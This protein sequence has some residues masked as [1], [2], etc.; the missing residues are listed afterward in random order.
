VASEERVGPHVQ[1]RTPRNSRTF[2]VFTDSR[3]ADAAPDPRPSATIA[4]RNPPPK[5]TL[6]STMRYP[7]CHYRA[8]H[9][10]GPGI[11]DGN[12]FVP[13]PVSAS[14]PRTPSA[15]RSGRARRAAP[16]GRASCALGWLNRNVV[17]SGNPPRSVW[18]QHWTARRHTGTRHRRIF[19]S[20]PPPFLRV[21]I[22]DFAPKP[23]QV[24]PR[25][26]QLGGWGFQFLDQF[27]HAWGID[28]RGNSR[29]IC[30]DLDR[31]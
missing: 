15:A 18:R 27:S 17:T 11:D 21:E 6:G 13:A 2:L 30:F 22:V 12:A 14:G 8:T 24:R 23:S 4:G 3:G 9:S 20:D 28:D 1:A 16:C 29:M 25:A 7:H 5:D 19:R 10:A 31:R 26:A